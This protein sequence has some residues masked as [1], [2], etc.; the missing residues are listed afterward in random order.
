[1]SVLQDVG[2]DHLSSCEISIR[3]EEDHLREIYSS[4]QAA[5]SCASRHVIIHGLESY[6]EDDDLGACDPA[7]GWSEFQTTN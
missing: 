1:M 5:A 2:A 4:S 6:N 7:W 3:Q